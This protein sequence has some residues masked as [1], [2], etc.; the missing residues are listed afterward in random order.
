[1]RTYSIRHRSVAA[2]D[3]L[4]DVRVEVRVGV[5][6]RRLTRDEHDALTESLTSQVMALLP[7]LRHLNV[8][9]SKVKVTR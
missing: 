8:P 9:L 7:G 2:D 6:E 5:R 4:I 3:G 1:M